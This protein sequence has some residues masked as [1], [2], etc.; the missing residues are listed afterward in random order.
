MQRMQVVGAIVTGYK[1]ETSSMCLS[2][3]IEEIIVYFD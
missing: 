3:K 2:K 1:V